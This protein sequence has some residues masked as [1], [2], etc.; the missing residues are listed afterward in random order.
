V[1]SDGTHAGRLALPEADARALKRAVEKGCSAA[2]CS[3]AVSSVEWAIVGSDLFSGESRDV[4]RRQPRW[5]AR[6]GLAVEALVDA[7]PTER[8]V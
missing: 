7:L 4:W 1:K 5:L 8:E 3:R 2:R 6:M